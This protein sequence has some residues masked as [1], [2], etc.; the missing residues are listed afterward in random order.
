ML[1]AANRRQL[2]QNE[3]SSLQ[4]ERDR[5]AQDLQAIQA[6]TSAIEFTPEGRILGAND[7]FLAMVGYRRE[8]IVGQHHR[9]FCTKEYVRSPGYKAFWETLAA[10]EAHRGT[11][12]R[13]N[14]EG[15]RCWLQA[16][17]FPVR[18]D[19]GQVVKVIKIASDV[20]AE[21]EA[22][23]DRE[24]QISALNRS[25]TVIEFEPD[26]TI[27]WANENFLKTMGYGLDQIKGK[28]HRLFCEEQFYKENPAFWSHLAAGEFFSGQ[29][30]RR[31]SAGQRIWVE[32]TY[33]PIFNN[34]GKVYKV[35]KFATDITARLE[36]F[37]ATAHLAAETSDETAEITA[38]ARHALDS[39][40]DS[41]N[42]IGEKIEQAGGVS[43]RLNDQSRSIKKIVSTIADIAAQTNLLAL[44]AAIEAARAG[45]AGRGFAVVA[46]EVRKL[47]SRTAE[48][49]NEITGVVDQNSG[50]IESIHSQMSSIRE[51]S[52]EEKERI[53]IV[54]AGVK[55]LEE[56]VL[57]LTGAVRCMDQ[58]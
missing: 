14:R 45:E 27:R 40:V 5:L 4:Q 22:L 25:L 33:N 7:L 18:N 2:A 41:S 26:G 11:F 28:H 3:I 1:F 31:N 17:Y 30:E 52:N 57:K 47:A 58:K 43:E 13:V 24:A 53:G 37:H 29:F 16:A 32:A 19:S 42:T 56:A 38:S 36:S 10:G 54:A 12:E 35:I 51:S 44:N 55:A 6:H 39:A 21:R 15:R 8:E 23:T 48:A 20:T 46:D 49:T 9:M 50:L 34:E